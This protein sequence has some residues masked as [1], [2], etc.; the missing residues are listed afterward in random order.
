MFTW[1]D[2][3]CCISV[4]VILE[5]TGID[6]SLVVHQLV[7]LVVWRG[8]ETLGFGVS[9]D[10]IRFD[11]LGLARFLLRFLDFVANV[12]THDDIIQ[13]GFALAVETKATDFALDFALLSF[14]AIILRTSRH[15][16]Y[17]LIVSLQFTGK[18]S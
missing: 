10:L 12:L 6:D 5:G 16:F 11:H 7:T 9:D 18:L 15:E 8:E 3:K 2:G 13:L 14:V 4:R 1:R 17:D